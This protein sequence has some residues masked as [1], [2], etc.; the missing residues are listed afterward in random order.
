MGL[1][2]YVIAVAVSFWICQVKYLTLGFHPRDY[3]Y[4]LQFSSKLLDQDSARL[5]SVNP[6]GNNWLRFN[7]ME[8]IKSFHQ[9]IHLE[10]IKYV[11]APLYT[12]TGSPVVLFLFASVVFFLPVLYL[13]FRFPVQ[14]EADGWFVLAA[15]LLYVAFPAS[16][17]TPSFDLRPYLFLGPS[18]LLLT[19]S[20]TFRRPLWEQVLWLNSLFLVREEALILGACGILF[21]F[22]QARGASLRRKTLLSLGAVWMAWSAFSLW[23]FAWTDFPTPWLH[24]PDSTFRQLADLLA[25]RPVLLFSV[26][27]GFLLLLALMVLLGRALLRIENFDRRIVIASFSAVLVVLV[28]QWTSNSWDDPGS[29]LSRLVSANLLS[30]RYSLHLG[31]LLG[32]IVLCR[33]L[34]E[35][36][37]WRRAGLWLGLLGVGGMV[38]SALSPRGLVAT[39]AEA[40][41]RT[42]RDVLAL[43]DSLDRHETWILTDFAT[44]QA[45]YDYEHVYV[46][47]RLPAHLVTGEKQYYPANAD[48]VQALVDT[49]VEYIVVSKPSQGQVSDFIKNGNL[50]I[51]TL[52]DNGSYLALKIIR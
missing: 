13:V 4:Y 12:V 1:A 37:T 50:A 33:L 38:A 28:Y 47:E 32:L 2:L 52:F 15:V 30:P 19:L 24:G 20:I 27:A 49:Q 14:T 51:T 5:Y 17:A 25:G 46:Y 21:A 31:A 16:L 43:R 8:G 29:A 36:G 3:A 7:G 22:F 18:F 41:G 9:A 23:Y 45:Y 10:P 40:D 39:L 34:S 11:Y 35:K 42:A 44:F 6:I 48:L 26:A